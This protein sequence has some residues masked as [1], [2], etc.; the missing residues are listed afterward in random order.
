MRKIV[1]VSLVANSADI[2]ESF[3]RHCLSFADEMVVVDHNSIDGTVDILQNLQ[4]EGL[5][6]EIESFSDVELFHAEIMTEL[7]WYAIREKHADII[8]PIDADE[9]LLASEGFDSCRKILEDLPLDE[10]W[11]V[12]MIRYALLTP[13]QDTDRFLLQRPCKRNWQER[14]PKIIIGREAFQE[15]MH[16]AQG[17][18]YVMESKIELKPLP[19]LHLAH[20]PWRN[21]NQI[22]TKIICGWVSNVAKYSVYTQRCSYW[23]KYFDLILRGVELDLDIPDR[24]AEIVRISDIYAQQRLRYTQCIHQSS[25][26]TL[27]Q[28]SESMAQEYAELRTSFQNKMLTVLVLFSGEKWDLLK[29]SILCA[30]NQNYL[31][32]EVF[33]VNLSDIDEQEIK[34]EIK[35]QGCNVDCLS[36]ETLAEH[37]CGEY[38]Q[39]IVAGDL[40]PLDFAQKRATIMASDADVNLILTNSSNL[41]DLTSAVPGQGEF[42][43]YMDIQ[44]SGYFTILPTK[45]VLQNIL[46]YGLLPS[47][48]LSG[49]FF[50]RD[51]MEQ[52]EWFHDCQTPAGFSWLCM[53]KLVLSNGQVGIFPKNE[54]LRSWE[55]V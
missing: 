29:E 8:L 1:V 34:E 37:V 27:M 24:Q 53:W 30:W 32:K 7:V 48:G 42:S 52:C 54:V 22:L 47:G 15:G 14:A 4:N 49:A 33:V 2:I 28:L 43:S 5:P 16:L 26:Q 25:L 44:V 19:N 46:R 10:V 45:Y 13:E 3:V 9:F 51:K 38:I 35:N 18:H 17:C 39:W 12:D 31:T 55:N 36:L 41:S 11:Q 20:F 40:V 23:K 50:S 6:V 21:K